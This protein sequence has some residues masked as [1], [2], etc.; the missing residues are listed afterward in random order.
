VKSPAAI[1]AY[2][3]LEEINREVF[4]KGFFFT[5]D[6]GKKDE[7]GLIYLLGRKKFFINKGG[8]KINPQE[9]EDVLE[10]HPAVE[11]VAVVGVPTAFKDEKVKAVVVS[12]EACSEAQLVDFCRGRIADFKVPSI[13]EFREALPKSPTGKVRKKL[14]V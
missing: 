3:G 7:E 11:E 8:Y 14:L 2:E 6:L 1:I 10:S 5:G 12:K 13:I 9:V 4:R